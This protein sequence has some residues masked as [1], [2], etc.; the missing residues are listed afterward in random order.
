MSRLFYLLFLYSYRVAIFIASFFN[1]K[2]QLWISGRKHLLQR[3]KQAVDGHTAPVIWVHCASLG[4]FEQGRTILET[5]KKEYPHFRVL[6]TFFSP[7]GYEIRKNYEHADWVFYLPLDTPGNARQFVQIVKPALAIFVKYEYWYHLLYELKKAGTPTLL[8]SALFRKNAIFFKSYG[9]FHRKMLRCFTHI[10]VQNAE[11]KDRL[12][13]VM[14][15][16]RITVAGDTRFDRVAQIAS[17]F[18]PIPA[19]ET[20][21]RR[22]TFT[23]VAGSTWADDEKKLALYLKLKSTNTSLII[24][25][26]EINEDHINEILTQFPGA[27]RFSRLKD[28]PQLES[29]VLVIDNIGML[30]RLYHYADITY[31]GG[32]FNKSGIHNTLEAAVFSKPVIFGPNYEKF[33]EAKA[34]IKNGGAI[35]YSTEDQLTAII[36]SLKNNVELRQ[37]AGHSAGR[38]VAENTG[39]TQIICTYIRENL[40]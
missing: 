31:I 16:D 37:E 4:E 26:H 1:K 19:I 34:L 35:S 33:A 22:N 18:T 40:R 8:V 39:A 38:F 10:F 23:V 15:E 14:P 13:S 12:T 21:T 6:L 30:S 5:L 3:L 9:G 17:G 25:P 24:A 7:S 29:P 2:A 11:S 32:G 28:D 36:E 20:F 27:I